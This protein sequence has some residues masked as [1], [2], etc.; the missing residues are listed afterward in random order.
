MTS[1]DH[2][3][4]IDLTRRVLKLEQAARWWIPGHVAVV[5][6]TKCRGAYGL[7]QL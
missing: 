7:L 1:C 2:R 4:T 5:F 6:H 3:V